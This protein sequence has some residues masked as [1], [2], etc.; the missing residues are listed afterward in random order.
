LQVQVVK[1]SNLQID[2]RDAP[3]GRDRVTASGF[4]AVTRVIHDI[5]LKLKSSRI[6][7]VRAL[8]LVR[9]IRAQFAQ[10][11]VGRR[12]HERVALLVSGSS[13]RGRRGG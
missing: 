1:Q 4:V 8:G 5:H 13:T 12:A 2:R 11:R 3:R 9:A 6:H 7:R 10:E